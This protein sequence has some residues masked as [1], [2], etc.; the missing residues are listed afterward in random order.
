M[1]AA[2][3]E[4]VGSPQAPFIRSVVGIWSGREMKWIVYIP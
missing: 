2:V 3:S 4:V 1:A